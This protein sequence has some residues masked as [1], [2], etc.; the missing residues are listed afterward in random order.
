MTR[1]APSQRPF[2]FAY[3][4]TERCETRK[5]TDILSAPPKLSLALSWKH[6]PRLL[7][8]IGCYSWASSSAG[9]APRSQRG[10]RGFES[11][12]VHQHLLQA[13]QLTQPCEIRSVGRVG[14]F[15]DFCVLEAKTP[16]LLS[17]PILIS[18]RAASEASCKPRT[19][20]FW[21]VQT[22]CAV[23]LAELQLSPSR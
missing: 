5:T 19:R 4:S 1:R 17:L 13:Q 21:R 22:R 16:C 9:R 12:L 6:V 3:D 15:S 14:H 11:P 10:G 18:I 8:F 20:E 23:A 2:C 7:N